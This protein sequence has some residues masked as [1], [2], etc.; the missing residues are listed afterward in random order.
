MNIA[1][2]FLSQKQQLA[3]KLIL[4]LRAVLFQRHAEERL[5]QA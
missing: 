5:T 1:A 3:V 4:I 2:V